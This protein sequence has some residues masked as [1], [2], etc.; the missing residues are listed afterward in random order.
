MYIQLEEYHL[1]P[2][3]LGPCSA[4]PVKNVVCT[5]VVVSINMGLSFFLAT[6]ICFKR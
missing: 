3:I 6:L 2:L 1:H 4:F 5:E